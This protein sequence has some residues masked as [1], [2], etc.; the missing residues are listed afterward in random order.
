M[1][2]YEYECN[3]CHYKDDFI[4]HAD[5]FYVHKCPK[6]AVKCPKWARYDNKGILNYKADLYDK[7]YTDQQNGKTLGDSVTMRRIVSAP[8]INQTGYRFND[9]RY[10]RGKR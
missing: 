9:A 1:P 7:S 6:C 10:S 4:E 5:G 3:I 8:V 2:I